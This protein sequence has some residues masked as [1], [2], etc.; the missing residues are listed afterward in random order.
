MKKKTV[1]IAFA[2]GKKVD[3][4]ALCSRRNVYK[5]EM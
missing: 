3:F 2:T 5:R 1:K 4:V